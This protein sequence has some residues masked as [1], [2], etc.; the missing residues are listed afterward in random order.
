[1]NTQQDSAACPATLRQVDGRTVN[2]FDFF[3]RL[4]VDHYSVTHC[5]VAQLFG[6]IGGRYSIVS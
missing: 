5:S 4:A 3:Y 2:G 1:M 6:P